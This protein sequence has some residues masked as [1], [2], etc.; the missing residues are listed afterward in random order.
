M[1]RALCE[2]LKINGKPMFAP[3]TEVQ[4]QFEDLDSPESGRDDSGVMHRVVIRYK[5]LKG[6]FEFLFLCQEDYEYMES[7]FPDE[8]DFE[9]THP[10]RRD[11]DKDTVSRCYRSVYGISWVNQKTNQIRNY[12]FNIIEC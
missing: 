6:T 12:K 5:V 4:F 1:A 11:F 10:D 9:F 2:R 3:D 8:P 7:L